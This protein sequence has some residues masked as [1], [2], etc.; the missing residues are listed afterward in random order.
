[1]RGFFEDLKPQENEIEVYALCGLPAHDNRTTRSGP[2]I[3]GLP[4]N[5]DRRIRFSLSLLV[6][7]VVKPEPV[8]RFKK[9][10]VNRGSNI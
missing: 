5:N 10:T 6:N 9:L 7:R 3:G 1:M 2:R 4:P 8:N